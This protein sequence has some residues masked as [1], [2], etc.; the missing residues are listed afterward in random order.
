MPSAFKWWTKMAKT[1][2]HVIRFLGLKRA[3][4]EAQA[5]TMG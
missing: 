3:T 2:F 1:Y 5:V 4:A